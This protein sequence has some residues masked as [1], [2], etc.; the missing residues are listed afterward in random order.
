MRKKKILLMTSLVL[1]LLLSGCG[2]NENYNINKLTLTNKLQLAQENPE[3]N[4]TITSL[5]E[6]GYKLSL[7]EP[8]ESIIPE[9][10]PVEKYIRICD[11]TEAWYKTTGNETQIIHATTSAIQVIN[12]PKSYTIDD[13]VYIDGSPYGTAIEFQDK[14]IWDTGDLNRESGTF[15]LEKDECMTELN[16]KDFILFF[17]T[18]NGAYY[19][20][21]AIDGRD[22]GYYGKQVEE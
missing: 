5:A 10:Y 11:Y 3:F 1:C 2:K 6:N 13:I 17:N 8:F 21:I 22:Y 14:S 20:I 12:L 16:E 19:N 7:D 18:H 4:K 15:D 9:E